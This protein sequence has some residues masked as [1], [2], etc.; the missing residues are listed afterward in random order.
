M[1]EGERVKMEKE[2]IGDVAEVD[3]PIEYSVKFD[4][5][6][7]LEGKREAVDGWIMPA[8]EVERVVNARNK[9]LEPVDYYSAEES[10]SVE[11]IHP[12]ELR[13]VLSTCHLFPPFLTD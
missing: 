2:V 11:P 3:C 5:E 10:D 9:H 6:E 12:A 13:C 1:M 7:G 4:E 8:I